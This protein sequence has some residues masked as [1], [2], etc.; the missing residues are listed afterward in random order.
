[1]KI[2][3]ISIKVYLLAKAEDLFPQEVLL[4]KVNVGITVNGQKMDEN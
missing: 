2:P 4:V 3:K 1:M